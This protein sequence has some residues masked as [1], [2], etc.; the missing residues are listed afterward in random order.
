MAASLRANALGECPPDTKQSRG[1]KEDL[2]CFVASL[3]AMDGLF[4]N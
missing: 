4:E 3:L 2:D 1:H